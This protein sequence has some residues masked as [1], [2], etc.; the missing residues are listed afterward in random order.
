MEVNE[1]PNVEVLSRPECLELLA[2]ATVGRVGVSMGALPAILPVHFA[3]LGQSV[4]FRTIPGTRLDIA[5]N[6]AVIAFE[7][8]AYEPDGSAG[9][10]VLVQGFALEVTDPGELAE[11]K[12]TPITPWRGGELAERLLRI[13][14]NQMTG[15]QFHLTEGSQPERLPMG[16]L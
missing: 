3:L 11:A 15:R 9:W 12:S 8:D 10:S 2:E 6:G 14:I 5:T 1:E 7:A 13:D 16:Q 4:L